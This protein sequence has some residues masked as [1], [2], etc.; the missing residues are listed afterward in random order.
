MFY[1]SYYVGVTNNIE[2]RISE[3]NLGFGYWVVNLKTR[4]K[5]LLINAVGEVAANSIGTNYHTG[6]ISKAQQ[7]T[8]HAGLGL[9]NGTCRRK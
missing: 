9:W 5:N 8:L 4:S 2:R 6:E 3:H 7:L 1:Q